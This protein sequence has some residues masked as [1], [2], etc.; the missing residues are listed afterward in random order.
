M[1]A[2]FAR[3]AAALKMPSLPGRQKLEL[4][5]VARRISASFKEIGEAADSD[6]TDA[7]N[8]AQLIERTDHLREL[9][10]T[11]NAALVGLVKQ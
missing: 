5:V 11:A 9:I 3:I 8:Y 2:L 1:P 6:V 4:E 7:A 10:A